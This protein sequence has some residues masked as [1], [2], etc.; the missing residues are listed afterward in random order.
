MKILK[1]FMKILVVDI[2]WIVYFFLNHACRS[3]SLDGLLHILVSAYFY[4][5]GKT[6]YNMAGWYGSIELSSVAFNFLTSPLT[7]SRRLGIDPVSFDFLT[8]PSPWTFGHRLVLPPSPWTPP[9]PSSFYRRIRLPHLNPVAFECCRFLLS[10]V[11]INFTH[12]LGLSSVAF[13]F[14]LFLW[15]YSPGILGIFRG[16][17]RK[18]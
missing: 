13:A 14:T 3:G 2:I 10:P 7:F 9:P 12:C 11:D 8:S 18:K 4:F 17:D 16:K 5:Q 1:V 15:T 6:N